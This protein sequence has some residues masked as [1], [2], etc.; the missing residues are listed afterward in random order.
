MIEV[1]SM[2]ITLPFDGF[3]AVEPSSRRVASKGVLWLSVAF[4]EAVQ[5]PLEWIG[6][7]TLQN[8]ELKPGSTLH[9]P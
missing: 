5:T 3:M 6:C 8:P 9:E 1:P 7:R 4:W 2:S